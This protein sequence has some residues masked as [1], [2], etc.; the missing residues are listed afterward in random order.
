[1]IGQPEA[2]YCTGPT[3]LQI[4]VP[5]DMRLGDASDG[6]ATGSGAANTPM[7]PSD[8]MRGTQALS[9]TL[10]R[11]PK[12]A[13]TAVGN[14]PSSPANGSVL[15]FGS[16]ANGS[17]GS[18]DVSIRNFNFDRVLD[19][20]TSQEMFFK[21]SGMQQLIQSSLEG[22]A[23]YAC[24]HDSH[25]LMMRLNPYIPLR[26]CVQYR[27]CIRSDRLWQD[28]HNVWYGRAHCG[29]RIRESGHRRPHSAMHSLSLR[30]DQG[31]L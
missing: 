19:S 17:A 24:A 1:M 2:V 14:M 6:T 10:S 31:M 18:A 25:G 3:G 30:R 11:A 29:C 27:V 23:R 22:Y 9:R 7:S 8:T 26:L 28:L 20:T 21:L 12:S 13:G 4:A 16:D 15:D 5:R